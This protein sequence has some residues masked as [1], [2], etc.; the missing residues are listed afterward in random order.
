MRPRRLYENAPNVHSIYPTTVLRQ[1][2]ASYR[3]ANSL[4]AFD[5]GDTIK[6]GPETAAV[7][8]QM[9]PQ[10][11]PNWITTTYNGLPLA[12]LWATD[13]G[14]TYLRSL[15]AGW[16]KE[17]IQVE[18]IW[19]A[20]NRVLPHIPQPTIDK[21][22][23]RESPD[24][25][26]GFE[27]FIEQY[28]GA[29]RAIISRGFPETVDDCRDELQ[30]NGSRDY[31]YARQDDKSEPLYEIMGREGLTKLLFAGDLPSDVEAAMQIK[32]GP[33]NRQVDVIQVTDDLREA[34]QHATISITKD[35]RNLAI[36]ASI[37]RPSQSYQEPFQLAC[38]L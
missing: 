29:H 27:R 19:R 5:V 14:V 11:W 30:F 31:T 1:R 24:F 33:G 15:F 18:A 34:H 6:P 10:N 8:S 36:L 28:R 21:V 26:H 25:Y 32:F 17:R 23:L 22:V 37:S 12:P 20:E 16:D 2:L 9:S 4:V 35:W 3:D 38:S 13:L 7:L